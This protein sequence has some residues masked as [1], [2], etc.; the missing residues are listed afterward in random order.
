MGVVQRGRR[1]QSRGAAAAWLA[2]AC[3]LIAACSPA[4]P[5]PTPTST[6]QPAGIST[7][8]PSPSPS[9]TLG[10]A[11]AATRTAMACAVPR[12][13]RVTLE[14]SGG[15]V[16]V[17]RSVEVS[18]DGLVVARDLQDGT[19]AEA[20]LGSADRSRLTSL[21]AAACPERGTARLPSCAD[22]YQYAYSVEMEGR[23]V[24]GLENDV[25]LQSSRLAPWIDA[26]RS[27]WQE[28]VQAP[29]EP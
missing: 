4:A 15:L 1:Q 16:G 19:Q 6:R 23:I 13:W 10:P 28:A 25:S 24:T 27:I 21:L 11:A 12:A 8:T 18:S 2:A 7:L 29:G 5:S 22:C 14:W 17:Q 20:T 9:P 3:L 26:L